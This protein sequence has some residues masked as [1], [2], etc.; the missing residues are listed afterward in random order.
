MT[1]YPMRHH[2]PPVSRIHAPRRLGSAGFSIVE[3]MGVLTVFA[4][5][6]AIGASST[7]GRFK[8]TARTVETSSMENIGEALRDYS[9]RT[10][11]IP[12]QS[13]WPAA[14]A[15]ELGAPV[16]R[17]QSTAA[18]YARAFI[19]DPNLQIGPATLAASARKLPFVQTAGGTVEPLN[20]RALI[21]SSIVAPLPDLTNV[22][23]T[24]FASLWGTPDQ[25]V[26]AGWTNWSG[27]GEDLRIQ[28]IDLAPLFRRVVLGNLDPINPAVFSIDSFT[29]LVTLAVG[30]KTEVWYLDTTPLNLHLSDGTLQGQE[31]LKEDTSYIFENG[32]WVRYILYGI[33]PPLS[34]FGN[35]LEDFRA[36]PVPPSAA[37]GA[38]PQIVVDELYTFL[39]AYSD[40]ATDP[41]GSFVTGGPGTQDYY[42]SYRRVLDSQA[43]LDAFLSNLCR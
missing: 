1:P 13:G 17:I 6:A 23:A 10:R 28:R 30:A 20:A 37:S 2:P 21:V 29:N 15:T 11:T 43:R 19:V 3:L 42:P 16:N 34:N 25:T 8:R 40:W 7:I 22:N 33:R 4:I 38:T 36:S 27:T 9:L 32:R 24:V 12:A 31:L 41:A 39:R 14:L 18:G 5:L 35:I 26:P